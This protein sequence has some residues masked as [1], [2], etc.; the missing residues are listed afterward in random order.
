MDLYEESE[1]VSVLK[2]SDDPACGPGL[3]LY[4]DE[5]N[6]L[7]VDDS[8]HHTI[9]QEGDSKPRACCLIAPYVQSC[10]RHHESILIAGRRKDL[11]YE[12]MKGNLPDDQQMICVDYSAP[13]FSPNGFNVLELPFLM[14]QSSDPDDHVKAILLLDCFLESVLSKE[15][16][17]RDRTGVFT[18][19]R[20]LLM[21]V[22]LCMM[23]CCER[24]QVNLMNLM[25]MTQQL[26]EAAGSKTVADWLD[27][28]TYVD[29]TRY[30]AFMQDYFNCSRERK[31]QIQCY[32][33]QALDLFCGG[34]K[35]Q[36]C[37]HAGD[38]AWSAA[39][40][41]LHQPFYLCVVFPDEADVHR[42]AGALLSQIV[43][44]LKG[45]ARH[46]PPGEK[47]P[48][49]HMMVCGAGNIYIPV[50]PALAECTR[51]NP[52]K[53]TLVMQEEEAQLAHLYGREGQT[54]IDH[55]ANGVYIS[56]GSR[57]LWEKHDRGR[58]R[59]QVSMNG[60][61][62]LQYL[63][64]LPVCGFARAAGRL[65]VAPRHPAAQFQIEDLIER[66]R[67]LNGMW[68]SAD[69]DTAM[70]LFTEDGKN[71]F[72]LLVEECVQLAE[73]NQDDEVYERIEAFIAGCDPEAA[74][75]CG[76]EDSDAADTELPDVSIPDSCWLVVYDLGH[77][78]DSTLEQLA[79]KAECVDAQEEGFV[80]YLMDHADAS[81]LRTRIQCMGGRADTKFL[82][83]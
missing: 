60:G 58:E 21:G 65:P 51:E 11:V 53:L 57:S 61:R 70:A 79:R 80:R 25:R 32:A 22:T 46:C 4:M 17:R 2:R 35:M 75:L 39:N 28:L 14:M 43:L 73:N 34:P 13:G 50:L 48:R 83:E 40:L 81:A 1:I 24:E 31:A 49:V 3:P 10:F 76:D 52:F 15:Y 16:C 44:C 59:M 64:S 36:K 29:H 38:E 74:E 56:H 45:Q 42:Q 23:Q 18:G 26:D 5:G 30:Q 68:T 69:F 72:D 6:H 27:E 55:A 41:D 63:S 54:I 71:E 8:G 82:F 77:D 12:Q 78:G 37:L 7:Y 19:A 62:K 33:V 47:M 66:L 67:K 20:D 9:I